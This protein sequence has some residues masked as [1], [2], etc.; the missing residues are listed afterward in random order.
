[1]TTLVYGPQTD[2]IRTFLAAVRE[3]TPTEITAVRDAAWASAWAAAWA[4]VWDASRAAERDTE[5]DAA[6]AATWDAVR[7]ATWDGALPAARDAARDA[8]MAL[9]V[10]DLVGRYGLTREHIDVL[11]A[12]ILTV[13]PHLGHLFEVG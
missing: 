9:V 8:A 7:A 2:R 5:W 6:R 1:M 11:A 12:P 13:M 10:L 3:M 4:A